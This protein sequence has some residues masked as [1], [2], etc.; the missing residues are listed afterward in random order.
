MTE[1]SS[2]PSLPSGASTPRQ[3]PSSSRASIGPVLQFWK[4]FDLDSK[5]LMLDAQ[6]TTMKAEKESS[7]RSRKKLAE[8]TKSFRKLPD[9]EKVTG[10]GGL[11]RAY[12]EEI[13]SLTK[14]AKY[15]E[16][17]FFTLY[18]GLYA[19]PDPVAS[20]EAVQELKMS[21]VE[22]E[23]KRLKRELKEFEVEFS[24]LKNQDITIRKLEEQLTT[25]QHE[26]EDKVHD[27]VEAKTRDLEEQLDAKRVEYGQQKRDLERQLDNTRQELRDAFARLDAMQSE[28]FAHKRQTEL[29]KSSFNAELEVISHEA[30]QIQTLQLE[31]AQLKKQLDDLLSVAGSDGGEETASNS[32]PASSVSGELAQKEKVIASLRQELVHAREQ[33]ASQKIAAS[34]TQR[35]YTVKL[36]ELKSAKQQ[37]E[38]ELAT[39]PTP[40]RFNDVLH[41]LRVLQQLEYNIVEDEE[42]SSGSTTGEQTEAVSDI[43]KLLL[44]RVRRLEH[45]LK[46][47][48]LALEDIRGEQQQLQ[49]ELQRKRDT[50]HEQSVLIRNLEESVATLEQ[51][52]RA[53]SSRAGD[54]GAEILLGAMEDQY[55]SSQ[56]DVSHSAQS[57]E[58]GT[59]MFEIVRGQR[60]RFRERMKE[61]EG[62]KHKLE[63]LV[64]SHKATINRLENDNMQ[65]YQKI[66]YLQSYRSNRGNGLSS[67]GNRIKPGRYPEDL[68]DGA[69]ASEDVEM[70][71]K[72]MYEEKLNPFAQFNKLEKQQRY[73][74]LNTVDKILLNSS[75]MVL[76]H[77]IMR[78]IAFGYVLILHLLVVATLYTYM[79]SCGI[80]NE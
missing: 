70:R 38:S 60:D 43:E 32:A 65:L 26:V 42:V 68:E 64:A 55:Q 29:A 25:L 36:D 1:A 4:A 18:K 79:H 80:S 75:R 47:K 10:L 54:M 19:A 49:A 41:Q 74:N 39:R 58:G 9:P 57:V 66:R 8:T 28:L 37:L 5:R 59:K 35:E 20:L 40:E 69:G 61:L 52:K 34:E 21:D 73:S 77:P 33:V 7:L 3:K 56:L 72:G 48:E 62:E 46:Q 50:I 30:T 12:Q 76:A 6:G 22:E 15:A 78:S 63:E 44:G 24:S 14:R 45:S 23:N 31:N 17:A 16:N 11:L 67:A 13:D 27:Q 71:Y 53:I 51:R 2:A